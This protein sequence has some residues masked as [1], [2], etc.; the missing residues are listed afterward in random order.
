MYVSSSAAQAV[1]L[2]GKNKT[3][4]VPLMKSG[5]IFKSRWSG[6]AVCSIWQS[7][8]PCNICVASTVYMGLFTSVREIGSIMELQNHCGCPLLLW[9]RIPDS[10]CPTETKKI[11]RNRGLT[12][13]WL[14]TETTNEVP[15]NTLQKWTVSLHLTTYLEWSN[16]MSKEG[17]TCM[18][19]C[20]STSTDI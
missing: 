2:F 10:N 17:H 16:V 18:Q 11:S 4:H 20:Q 13:D 3:R 7:V 12:P 9:H 15:E 5:Q 8:Y 19:S 6:K 1:H 14:G